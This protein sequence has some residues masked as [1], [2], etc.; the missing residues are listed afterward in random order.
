MRENR[1]HG[2][3]GFVE[4]GLTATSVPRQN[5]PMPHTSISPM[6]S[7]RRGAKAIEFYKSAFSANVV[8]RIDAPDGAVVARLSVDEAEFWVA[9]E[10]PEHKNFSPETLGG[11]TARMVMIVDDPDAAFAKAIAA[12]ATAVWP[13]GNQHGWRLGRVVDPFGHHWEIGKPVS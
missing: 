13:V 12:G 1:T 7:V 8:Y 11:G 10:S 2:L 6:L 5:L 4:N 3:K 9:D